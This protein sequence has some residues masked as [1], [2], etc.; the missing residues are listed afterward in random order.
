MRVLMAVDDSLFSENVIRAVEAGILHENTEVLVLHVLQPVEPV[1]PPEMAQ[2]YARD[3][4]LQ[5]RSGHSA[6][7]ANDEFDSPTVRSCVPN[8][9]KESRSLF[10]D[11]LPVCVRG[12]QWQLNGIDRQPVFAL[13]IT[14]TIPKASSHL[15]A[16][17]AC[18]QY[19]GRDRSF[20]QMY[21]NVGC[22][23]RSLKNRICP[24]VF[25]ISENRAAGS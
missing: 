5:S 16:R 15:A 18:F 8:T 21:V 22:W 20:F 25:L 23:H 17:A 6:P 3:L 19:S 4:D 11:V 7:D 24:S 9:I 14:S 12:R 13:K 2:G 10:R 1:P